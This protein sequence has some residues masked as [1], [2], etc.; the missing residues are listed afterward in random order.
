MKKHIL[1]WLWVSGVLALQCGCKRKTPG[2]GAQTLNDSPTQA[3]TE[4]GA[5][6]LLIPAGQF[7]MGDEDEI[8][9]SPHRVTVSSFYMDTT[10]VTQTHFERIMGD[11]PSRWKA[12]KNPVEQVRWADAVRFCNKRS[13]EED[14]VPCYD[15]DTW[16]CNFSASGYRLPTEAQWEYAARAG[17]QTAY[18]SGKDDA[19]LADYAWFDKNAGGQPQPVGQKSPNAWGLYDMCGNLWQWCHDVYGVD[20]YDQSPEADPTGPAAGDTRVVRGGS[21]KSSADSCRAGYRYNEDP[22]YADVCFGYDI[23]GFRCVRNVPDETSVS[24]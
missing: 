22:G 3:V 23:Y 5:A 6:M 13:I 12:P 24:E 9:A 4:S 8:D 19:T 7:T 10:L 20:Y 21:W 15:L 1:I 18:I 11:N 17:T 14:L 16:A 2:E